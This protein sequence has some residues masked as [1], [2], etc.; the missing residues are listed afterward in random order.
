MWLLVACNGELGAFGGGT[1]GILGN[2]AC[3]ELQGGDERALR[4]RCEGQPTIRA[5]V[6]ASGD[7][8]SVAAKAEAE[9]G[10]ACERMGHDLAV[11][12]EQMAPKSGQSR[13]AAACNAVSIKIDAI[14]HAASPH[15]SSR[16]RLRRSVM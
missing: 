4:C 12:S 2:L 10:A 1:G 8:A 16:R 9:V 11:P 13:V 14:L 7:L 6:T 5:F 3:P 15:R